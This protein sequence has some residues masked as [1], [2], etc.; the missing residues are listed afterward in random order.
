[1]DAGELVED[2]FARLGI[3]TRPPVD[4]G[5]GIDLV[6]DPGGVAVQVKRRTLITDS[7]AARL[8]SESAHNPETMLLAVGDR[9]TRDARRLLLDRGAGYYDLRGHLALRT[10]QLVVD[11]DVEPIVERKDRKDALAGRAGLEVAIAILMNPSSGV[12]VRELARSLNRSPSTVSEVLGA[13]RRDDL[14]DQ[15]QRVADTGLFWEVAERWP[16]PRTYLADAPPAGKESR[17]TIPLRLGLADVHATGWALTDSV[18]AA[19]FGAPI[20]V[21]SDQPPVFYL[22]DESTL[23]RARTLLGVAPSPSAA[24]CVV[25]VGPVPAVCSRRVEIAANPS[26]WPLAHPLFVAL[27]LAQDVGRGR[28]ILSAWTPTGAWPRV[29]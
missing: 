13:L 14:I 17:A 15:R 12:A 26:E 21:R 8:L 5:T 18:A 25:R 2:A 28:E 24:G 23:R 27:D 4:R 9:V 1:M 20:A 6:L 16:T 7:D 22:P 29:W 11:T 10:A 3:R 19:A